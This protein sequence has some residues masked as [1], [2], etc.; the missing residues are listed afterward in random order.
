VSGENPASAALISNLDSHA[1]VGTQ[2]YRGLKLS[3]QH[4]SVNGVSV[5]A[6]YTLSR[7]V[8]L[9][10]VPNA[11]FG[12]GFT[13]PADPDYDFG[14]CEGDRTHVANGTLS[15]LTPSVSNRALDLLA[16]N[17]RLAGIVNVH[18]GSRLTVLSGRDS[19]FNGQAN[20]RV[21]QISNDVYG[22]KTLNNY[23][24]RAAFAQPAP[25]TFGTHKRN[26]ITGPGFWKIDLAVSRLVSFAS[27]QNVE[28]RVEVFNL[29]NTFNWGNP[30]TNF[31]AGTF[32]RITSMAGSGPNSFGPPASP[33]I[34]QFGVKYGF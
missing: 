6:N 18:S 4:R 11:Q 25:G 5:N 7:C 16:S 3:M 1:A 29:L 8:G 20:Q 32:G 26:S 13:N 2:E 33:R 9:E 10:M 23:L 14:Y 28:L 34:M 31:N 17:W 19:A 30:E 22:D 21:D 15:Y 24:N 12:I 27:T